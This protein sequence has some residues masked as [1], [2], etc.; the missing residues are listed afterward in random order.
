MNLVVGHSL[1]VDT[2]RIGKCEQEQHRSN[3]LDGFFEFLVN[4][5]DGEGIIPIR[6][7]D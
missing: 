5:S 3:H 2:Q 6:E 1:G 7:L 4:L